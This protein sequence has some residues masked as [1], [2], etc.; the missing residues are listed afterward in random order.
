ML[1]S[2]FLNKGLDLINKRE[3]GTILILFGL[4]NFFPYLL[5]GTINER[6][7]FIYLIGRYFKKYPVRIFNEKALHLF[8]SGVLLSVMIMFI[9]INYVP[10]IPF[11]YIYDYSSPIIILMAISFFFLFKNRGS[12]HSETINYLSS[13]VFAV[14]LITDS[15]VLRKI[16]N[17]FALSITGE[18]WFYMLLFATATVFIFSLLDIIIRKPIYSIFESQ[19]NKL[20]VKWDNM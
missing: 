9:K 4:F 10:Q 19:L 18:N 13:G 7:V 12:F 15:N 3:F 6:F 20:F 16:F 14:F 2:P 1:F 8:V 5:N 11:R 17:D